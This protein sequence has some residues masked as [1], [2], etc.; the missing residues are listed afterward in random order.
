MII[1]CSKKIEKG[2]W[3]I[4]GSIWVSADYGGI[5]LRNK[6]VL[7]VQ[8]KVMDCENE[9][10]EKIS[11]NQFINQFICQVWE[12]LT[13]NWDE[14]A[15]DEDG[16]DGNKS[17][18]DYRY[19]VTHIEII[20]YWITFR[21]YS[22]SRIL[23]SLKSRRGTPYYCI[24]MWALESEISKKRSEYLRFREPHCHSFGAPCL[25]NPCKYSH[26]PYISRK[27]NHWPTFCRW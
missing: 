27:Q 25:G 21:G 12:K 23:R 9:N 8:W 18:G 22:R 4:K 19:S 7:D 17:E 1:D 5:N 24:I 2:L 6:S 3:T 16:A 26:K 20:D 14:C 11:I 10:A 13:R 15:T